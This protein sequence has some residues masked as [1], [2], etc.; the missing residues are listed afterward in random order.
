MDMSDFDPAFADA[1]SA[2]SPDAAPLASTDQRDWEAWLGEV[3]AEHGLD[4]TMRPVTIERAAELTSMTPRVLRYME[5]EGVI[6]PRR[7]ASGYRL[8]D[9]D[10]LLALAL[11]AVLQG[12]FGISTQELRFLRRLSEDR[13]LAVAV[14]TLGRLTRRALYIEPAILEPAAAPSGGAGSA[15]DL[16]A[17][18]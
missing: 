5:N 15:S 4:P 11:L 3:A 14:R 8:Y 6:T 2:G 1:V 17:G 12:S 7:T 13:S 18:S 9:Y 10:D 16:E